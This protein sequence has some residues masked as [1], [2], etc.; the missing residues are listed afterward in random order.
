[1]KAT[2]RITNISRHDAWYNAREDIDPEI[3]VIQIKDTG[4]C[5]GDYSYVQANCMLEDEE[6]YIVF[7]AVKVEKL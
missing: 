6:T 1:M 2:H 5:G 3:E 4:Y 7:A